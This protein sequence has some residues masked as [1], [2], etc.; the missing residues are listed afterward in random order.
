MT[1]HFGVKLVLSS[2]SR[3]PLYT[4]WLIVCIW[5][6]RHSIKMDALRESHG[7]RAAELSAQ[8]AQLQVRLPFLCLMWAAS[9]VQCKEAWQL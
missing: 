1:V 5:L 7:V 8:L 2:R 9:H 4:S 6:D 3:L